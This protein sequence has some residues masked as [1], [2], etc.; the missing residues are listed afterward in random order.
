MASWVSSV[1]YFL[2]QPETPDTLR[3]PHKR[4]FISVRGAAAGQREHRNRVGV[5][6][7]E[8]ERER[9]KERESRERE[10]AE[11]EKSRIENKVKRHLYS[12]EV[13]MGSSESGIGT[14]ERCIRGLVKLGHQ[15]WDHE[16]QQIGRKHSLILK[17][18]ELT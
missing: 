2:H 10:R 18:T 3:E 1:S 8:I 4:S 16:V 6:E 13:G 12:L 14:R 7:G 9:T 5:H 11:T 15:V 17:G